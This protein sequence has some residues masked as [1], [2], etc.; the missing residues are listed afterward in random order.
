MPC[1]EGDESESDS[2]NQTE[3]PFQRS[4]R[5]QNL[6]M[7]DE[8]DAALQRVRDERADLQQ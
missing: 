2:E 1:N 7:R 6:R 4:E 3:K 8:L 5:N